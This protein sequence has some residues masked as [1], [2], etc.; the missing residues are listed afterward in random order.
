MRFWLFME[1]LLLF[2]R[3]AEA[4]GAFTVSLI[5]HGDTERQENAL[6]EARRLTA[7]DSGLALDDRRWSS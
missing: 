1:L 4:T 3:A 2:S 7:T 5:V 6:R